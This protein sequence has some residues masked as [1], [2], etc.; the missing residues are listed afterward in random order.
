MLLH[1]TARFSRLSTPTEK[2]ATARRNKF[3][4]LIRHTFASKFYVEKPKV[5]QR[6]HCKDKV[7]RYAYVRAA[8]LHLVGCGTSVSISHRTA[9][10]VIGKNNAQL[11]AKFII[12]QVRSILL[13]ACRKAYR[14]FKCTAP[15]SQPSSW[16]RA[17]YRRGSKRAI[18]P[19]Y[20]QNIRHQRR[21]VYRSRVL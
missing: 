18:L 13:Y 7:S 15:I 2:T 11:M 5:R 4:V 19:W 8:K 16:F 10:D 14:S 20:T 12:T 3:G 17:Q 9:C 6:N 21:Q 1:E